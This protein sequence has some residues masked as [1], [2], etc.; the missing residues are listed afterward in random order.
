MSGESRAGP[1]SL[2]DASR[3]YERAPVPDGVRLR[4]DANEGVDPSLSTVLHALRDGGA[5]VLR[6]YPDAKPFE[7]MLARHFGVEASQVFVAAGAD[8]VV[9]RC[10][11]AFLPAGAS[12]LIAE[13]GFEMFD[14]YAALCG[15]R[16]ATAPWSAGVFPI[17]AMLAGVDDR[18]AVIALVTPNNPT[19]EVATLDDLRRLSAAAPNALVVLD[20]AYVEFADEDLTTAALTMPNVV[21]VRT[22]S[23]AWGLAGC[24][25]GYAI[26]ATRII[27]AL[28]AAGGPFPVSAASLLI[29]RSQFEHRVGA[30]DAY[31]A[32]IRTERQELHDLL[33]RLNG[34]P[35]VSS[36]NFVFAELGARSPGVH[37]SLVSHGV[38]VRQIVRKSGEPLGLRVSLPGDTQSFAML[39]RALEVALTN[40][41][42]QT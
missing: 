14:Q 8:E 26:G 28:R 23:K 6:R 35:R 18:V 41:G 12:L 20:H 5:E 31:V 24:R 34:R 7:G 10:C 30:R 16:V 11:R 29:A 3:A 17:D 22:F 40:A 4:L 38:L 1:M 39:A 9:D 32:R 27:R 13:P 33:T 21:V 25:V 19:G 37:A 2:V 42:E 36:A 15:A